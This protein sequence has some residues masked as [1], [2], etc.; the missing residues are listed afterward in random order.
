MQ[1]IINLFFFFV[2]NPFFSP[3]PILNTDSAPVAHAISLFTIILLIINRKKFFLNKPAFI[4]LIFAIISLFF[5]LPESTFQL[6]YR[7]GIMGAFLIYWFSTNFLL[8][9]KPYILKFSI[10]FH[11]FFVC[12]HFFLPNYFLPIGRAF[13]RTIKLENLDVSLN[14]RGASGLAAENSFAAIVGMVDIILLFWFYKRKEISKE[15]FIKYSVISFIPIILSYSGSGVFITAFLILLFA[16][17]KLTLFISK[18]PLKINA[19]F[20]K[21]LIPSFIFIIPGLIFGF[22]S[23]LSTRGVSLFLRVIQDPTLFLVDTS[24]TDRLIG[25]TIGFLSLFNFPLGLGGGS[26]PVVA[27][28]INDKYGVTDILKSPFGDAPMM[29]TVSSFGTYCAEFGLIFVSVYLYLFYF[30][31]KNINTYTIIASSLSFLLILQSF[32][33]LFPPTYLL[34][35]TCIVSNQSD[36]KIS[37]INN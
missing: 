28:Y 14:G 32:S 37:S 4:L 12:L 27:K 16:I 24:I 26:Y 1:I 6:R 22:Q 31:N 11:T 2:L 10:L 9:F 13:V 25:I 8:Q 35:A 5:V 21:F 34:L 3:L 15:V 30:S 29:T 17:I 23:L 36:F 20:A 7:V 33:I 18:N 19:K